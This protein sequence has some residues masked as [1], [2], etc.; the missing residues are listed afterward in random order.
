MNEETTLAPAS[1]PVQSAS[2]DLASPSVTTANDTSIL[3]DVPDDLEDVQ[4]ELN[5]FDKEISKAASALDLT[6]P[7]TLET[8][9]KLVANAGSAQFPWSK[10]K[11]LFR[12]KLE[13][14]IHEFNTRLKQ[15]H[16]QFTFK[17]SFFYSGLSPCIQFISLGRIDIFSLK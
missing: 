15:L 16:L 12:V 1:S 11:P 5:N 10:I 6:I 8:Y 3:S 7:N 9:L 2:N 13:Q 4:L 17:F 14:V